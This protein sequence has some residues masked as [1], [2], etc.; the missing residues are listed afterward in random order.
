MLRGMNVRHLLTLSIVVAAATACRHTIPSVQPKPVDLTAE[1]LSAATQ[2]YASLLQGAPADSVAAMY[3]L[4]GALVLPGRDP[5]RGREA[6]RD[7]LAP[8]EK[9]TVV[10]AVDMTI[11]T[12]SVNGRSAIT[13]GTYRQVAG[14]RDTTPDQ[15]REYRGRYH[16]RWER[17]HDG[18]WRFVEL[19]MKPTAPR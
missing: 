13:A 14:P 4:T 12:L 19:V 6:I 18:A 17:E 15:L 3:A 2:T 1:Q 7:F 5:L 10:A 8:L 11:D 16:A 9:A